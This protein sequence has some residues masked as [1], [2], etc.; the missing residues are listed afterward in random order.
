MPLLLL[1]IAQC[2]SDP[3]ADGDEW[4]VG[5][6]DCDDA[7]PTVY[8]GAEEIPYDGIDQDCS[9]DDLNDLD[10]D[11]HVGNQVGGDDCRDDDATVHPSAP[12][13]WDDCRDSDCD[14]LDFTVGDGRD[15]AQVISSVGLFSPPAS[16][17]AVTA[18]AGDMAVSVEYDPGF[19]AG[20]VVMLRTV[21]SP[22]SSRVGSFELVQ[23]EAIDGTV[24]TLRTT[25][26]S[27]YD[28]TDTVRVTRVWQWESVSIESTGRLYAEGWDGNQGGDLAFLVRD[29]LSIAAGGGIDAVGRGYR[30]G[31]RSYSATQVGQ[32][33]ESQLGVGSRTT[34]SSLTGGGGG[35]AQSV[36][37]ADGGGGGHATAGATG[38]YV[39]YS[40]TTPGAGG[41]TFGDSS[42]FSVQL[43]GAGGSGGLDVDPGAGAY[44]GAGGAG[45]GALIAAVGTLSLD[46][47]IQ[48]NGARGEDGMISGGAS[49]GGGG[50]GAGGAIFLEV[51]RLGSMAGWLEAIGGT[52]GAGSEAGSSITY[53]G[54]GGDGRIRLEAPSGLTTAPAAADLC[55]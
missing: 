3:D 16:R 40:G 12:E 29:T 30:G 22:D 1:G 10:G 8:P 54:T 5:D 53:G 50:G 45:G 33:G 7:D 25:L 51:G 44:G 11:G 52:G 27:T 24:L 20:D 17:L 14:G 6:G 42:L 39:G 41:G 36:V 31:E 23:V 15:G 2:Q 38:G 43:G 21:Y 13:R 32:Q 46:G 34:S 9:G 18:P 28:A 35:S 49:P 47:V 19:T 48:V 4:T 26:R 37:H 55:Q